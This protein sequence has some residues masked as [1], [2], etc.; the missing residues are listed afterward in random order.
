[1]M[2]VIFYKA[3]YTGQ[4]KKGTKRKMIKNIYYI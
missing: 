3:T 1:M 2:F 4:E